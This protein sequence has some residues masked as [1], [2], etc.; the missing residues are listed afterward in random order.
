LASV[1]TG[2]VAL[3]LVH[4]TLPAVTA[5]QLVKPPGDGTHMFRRILNESIPELRPL[6][7]LDQLM[8]QPEHTLLIVL[9]E[10]GAISELDLDGFVKQGGA[11]LIATDR[12]ARHRSLAPFG[13]SMVG[14]PVVAGEDASAY[15]GNRD[16]VYVKAR[17]SGSAVF[18][19]PRKPATNRP[20]YLDCRQSKLPIW[21]V[22]PPDVLVGGEASRFETYVF[23][24]GGTW[25]DGRI[26]LLS[27]H[28]VFIN[29]MLWQSD[30]ANRAF[31]YKCLEWLTDKGRR[32]R[33]LFL[34][35]GTTQLRFDVPLEEVPLPPVEAV[36]R[37][38]NETMRGM[39]QENRFNLL[40]QGAL[41]RIP[42]APFLRA[43]MTL[44]ALVIG[45]VGLIWLS[46]AKYNRE[47]GTPPL[48][49][50][51]AQLVPSIKVMDQ[52][53]RAMLREGNFWETARGIARQ[54]LET[55][56]VTTSTG[57]R[58]VLPPLS[59]TR[60]WRREWRLRR[61]IKW[62]WRL[63][64][65]ARPMRVNARQLARLRTEIE[66]VKAAFPDEGLPADKPQP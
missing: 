40:I 21:A 30:I 53:Q 12:D 2:L 35:E 24:A 17:E 31:A 4:L 48:E 61:Q 11:A 37:A 42:K 55:I 26:L 5:Q 64:Y 14:K 22:F 19:D 57:G 3:A 49:W 52:R 44:S 63:A 23:A 33:V 60:G 7:S 28:S 65:G 47:P 58:P 18:D 41:Q 32:N 16:W 15:R 56:G 8:E 6:S 39:E 27:D 34:E 54:G 13:V 1:A 66:E 36:V 50:G 46:L 51:L 25:G 45:I 9:G 38:V 43:L 29:A 59:F 62:L 20:G 10:T